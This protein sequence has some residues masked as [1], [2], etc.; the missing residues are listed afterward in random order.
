VPILESLS[1]QLACHITLS[2]SRSTTMTATV[3]ES[4]THVTVTLLAP[5]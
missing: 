1:Q 4:V 3:S 5:T 2:D